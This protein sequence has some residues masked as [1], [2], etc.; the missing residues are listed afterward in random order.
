MI[1]PWLVHCTLLYS[2]CQTTEGWLGWVN[3]GGWLQHVTCRDHVTLLLWDNLRWLW[4]RELIIFKLCLLVYKAMNGLAP[5][6]MYIKELC[7]PV[8]TVA[9]RSA[10][11]GDLLVHQAPTGHSPSLFPLYRTVCLWTSELH[12]HHLQCSTFK[13]LLKTYLFSLSYNMQ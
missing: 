10:A 4:V 13:N 5:S 3:L 2:L 11:R 8:T 7:V 6:Y 9:T 12:V 1:R